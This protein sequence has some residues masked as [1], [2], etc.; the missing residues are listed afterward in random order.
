MPDVPYNELPDEHQH[1]SQRAPWL[2]AA[3]L[4][5]NDGLVSV[6]SLMLGVEGGTNELHPVVLAGVAGLVAGAL[7]MAVG[8]FVSVS[9]QR[10]AEEAD[11]EKERKEQAKGPAARAHELEELTAIYEDRGLSHGLARQVAEE[12]TAKDVIRAHA[13]DELGIDVDDMTNPYQA[14]AS[15]ALAFI[16]GA[17]LP[18]LAAAF[19]EDPKMRILSVVL[20]SAFG[21][22]TFGVTGAVLGGAGV[23][24]GGT[25]V[26]VGGLVAMGITYGFGR[27]FKHGSTSMP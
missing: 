15:S 26:L 22:T 13:R 8:E 23:L 21:L 12:L 6:A 14:A 17:G 3:V 18:L 27:L 25:R 5:A 19:I 20:V 4:G 7:S 9:S 11:I 1:F 2:R 10:D 24:K 16:V